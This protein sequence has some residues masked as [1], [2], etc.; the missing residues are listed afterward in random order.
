MPLVQPRHR[1]LLFLVSVLS[2]S[3]PAAVS[4]NE[5]ELGPEAV[6][7]SSTEV[8]SDAEAAE[9]AP[10]TN[11]ERVG[12]FAAG[13]S[14]YYDSRDFTTLNITLFSG[15]FPAGF[16]FWG[17]IDIH[18]DHNAGRERFQL[19]RYFLE[20]RVRWQARGVLTGFGLEAEVNDLQGAGNEVF[21]FGVNYK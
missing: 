4:A 18:A 5:S 14:Y 2:S 12:P 6:V 10:E 11:G 17:F 16:N 1:A 9:P 19:S 8:D 20:F 3:F 21:R 7:T 15:R 13:I